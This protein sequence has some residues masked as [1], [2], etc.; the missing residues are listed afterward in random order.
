MNARQDKRVIY[1]AVF[2]GIIL[3][4][5]AATGYLLSGPTSQGTPS[6]LQYLCG[7]LFKT[8]LTF[9]LIAAGGG[10]IK[11]VGVRFLEDQSLKQAQLNERE[12]ERRSIIDE[13]VN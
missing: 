6:S 10:Y 4:F 1:T 7:E 2:I 8:A 5:G 3:S 11:I 13:F 12:A 9:T